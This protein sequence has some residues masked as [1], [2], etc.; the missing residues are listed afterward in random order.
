M[1]LLQIRLRNFRSY[2]DATFYFQPGINHICGRNAIGK[3][4][5]LE[6]I[7]LL[8]CGRSFRT[9][10]N[11]DLIHYGA[12]FF[13]LDALFV[14]HG[15]EQRLRL[16][17][18][19]KQKKIFINQTPCSSYSNLLGIVYGVIFTPDDARL[20]KGGPNERREF[21]DLHIAQS[22]PLY[23]HYLT[24]YDKAMR[25]RNF[26]LKSKQLKVIYPW[27]AEMA[28]AA[29]YI[30]KKRKSVVKDIS[31]HVC[32]TYRYISKEETNLEV[33]LK[34]TLDKE[35]GNIKEFFLEQMNKQRQRE[36]EVGFTL[37]GP[38]KDD[39]SFKISDKEVKLFGSEGQQRSSVASLR[40]A[41]WKRLREQVQMNPLMLVDDMG[42]SLDA[43]RKSQ[44]CGCLFEMGQVFLTSTDSPK[45]GFIRSCDSL[46]FPEQVEL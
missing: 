11:S 25:Q 28:V 1:R 35:D 38:H 26:L 18:D 16:M 46:I 17:F 8:I 2:K 3:T 34:S 27:E 43:S 4:T 40:I 15:V 24:R 5:I 37:V 29:D 10:Q 22:D 14:K 6:A 7:H 39:L 32:S 42:I 19:G 30:V 31:D 20:I 44:L 13:V 45:D 36:M 33:F 41:S 12:S 9:Q 23:V 21:L